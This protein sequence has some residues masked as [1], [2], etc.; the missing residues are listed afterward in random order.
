MARL[1]DEGRSDVDLMP[2]THVADAMTL[3]RRITVEPFAF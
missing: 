3:G 1:I 2:M